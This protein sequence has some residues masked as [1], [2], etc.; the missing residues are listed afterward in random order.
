LAAGVVID[1]IAHGPGGGIKKGFNLGASS[2]SGHRELLV[3][4]VI[5]IAMT[6]VY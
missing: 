1:H 5:S 2:G 4:V 3:K 6:I